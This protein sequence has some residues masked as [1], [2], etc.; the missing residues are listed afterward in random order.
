MADGNLRLAA[1]GQGRWA[2]RFARPA[3]RAISWSLL[4]EIEI[5]FPGC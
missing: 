5:L 4:A 3:C 1:A 2:T